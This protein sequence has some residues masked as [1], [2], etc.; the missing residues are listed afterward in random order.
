MN[1]F[2]LLLPDFN[3]PDYD[4]RA[5]IENLIRKS[6]PFIL[7]LIRDDEST[8]FGTRLLRE[9]VT[10]SKRLIVILLHSIGRTKAQDYLK[11]IVEAIFTIIISS[12]NASEQQAGT[13]LQWLR[14]HIQSEIA[15]RFQDIG[16]DT[17]DVIEFLVIRRSARLAQ[18]EDLEAVK[19][20][21]SSLFEPF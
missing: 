10:F 8:E 21:Y 4:A 16:L 13:A 9:I 19:N 15:K 7:N 6:L 18:P 5:S 20:L 1:T 3:A 17:I 11:K 2:L 14:R 12:G